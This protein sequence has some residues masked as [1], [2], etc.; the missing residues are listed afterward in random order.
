MKTK[1]ILIFIIVL[2]GAVYLNSCSDNVTNST[3]DTVFNVSGKVENWT[4]GSKKIVVKYTV[5]G[6]PFKIGLDTAAIT[7]D[8][9]FSCEFKDPLP[10]DL[11]TLFISSGGINC[12]GFININPPGTKFTSLILEVYDAGDS[13]TGYI[14][15]RNFDSQ[16]M[17]GSGF[18]YY[19]Y[20]DNNVFISGSETCSNISDTTTLNCNFTG[21]KGWQKISESIEEMT[22]TRITSSISNTEPANTKWYF[23]TLIDTQKSRMVNKLRFK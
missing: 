21:I 4:Y 13:L 12:T 17:P 19:I 20:L 2:S 14:E 8:G 9:N 6:Y 18:V 11:D 22:L 5:S 16:L 15:R 1:K 10:V 7:I 23:Y 3:G